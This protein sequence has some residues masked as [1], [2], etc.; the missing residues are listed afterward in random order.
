MKIV[1]VIPFQKGPLTEDL[2]YF[3][4]K[5]IPDGSIVEVSLR[6]KKLLGLVVSSRDASESKGELKDL[7]F[8][9]K[10]ILS[11]KEHS[12]IKK[13]YI[14]AVLL[15]CKYFVSNKNDSVTA[16]IPALLRNN[17]D[18]ISSWKIKKNI[19]NNPSKEIRTEKLLFQADFEDR[20][21]YYKT[22]IRS[23]FA[24]KKSIFVVLPTDQAVQEF[25]K[26]LKKGVEQFTFS[27]SGSDKGSKALRK[28][29]E[30]TTMEHPV[31][32]LG[33]AP[34]LSLPRYD[35]GSIIIEEESS[36][37]FRMPFSP[38]FD[39][40]IFAEIFAAKINARFILCDTLLRFETFAR[41]ELDD[42]TEVSPLSFRINYQ[43]TTEIV[44][45]VT[46]RNK[47][48]FSVFTDDNIQIIKKSINKGE[49]IFVFSLRKGL[50]TM[51][52]CR[53]CNDMITCNKCSAPLVL[54]LSRDGKKRMFI[55]NRCGGEKDPETR[56]ATCGSWNLFPLGIGAD[57]VFAELRKAM[58]K[59][60]IFKL[61]KEE[62]SSAKDAGE[63]IKQFDESRGSI[64]LGTQMALFY[65]KNKVPLSIIASFDSL[66][67]MPN[68]QMG[69]K[70][71]QLL[72]SI[73]SK[74]KDKL[75]IITKNPNDPALLALKNENLLAY[76]RD[77]LE[78]RRALG[79]PPYKR[80]IKITHLGNK[81]ESTIARS[82]LREV[83]AEYEMDIFSGFVGKL[84]DKYSTNALIKLDRKLWSLPSLIVG[85]SIDMKLLEKLYM[86]G[87]EF[88]VNVD[89]DSLL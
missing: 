52:V 31:L 47:R 89:P 44:E 41:K 78:D 45:R 86:L 60:K 26:I 87:E 12:I 53:D 50:A 83:F 39:L 21:S 23:S 63:V 10:K 42:F 59:V 8:N 38:N 5:E 68:F 81:D 30:M 35:F 73:M 65:F 19:I 62:V 9:L 32:V 58:P 2:T 20:I 74:T 43:G 61:D 3:T 48:A 36:N 27:F 7:N 46:E 51:T 17:Y 29:E 40:R 66:W 28:L 22:L 72:L 16:L 18:L 55:C 64:L 76:A 11:I 88:K 6:S 84:K 71:I 37:A 80:F 57:T 25:E 15:A 54:Y 85:G 33:T 82:H 75:I 13:K 4:S 69:E 24:E 1:T 67:G 79:Y 56:C 14:E 34:Y 77:E 49:N 70:I